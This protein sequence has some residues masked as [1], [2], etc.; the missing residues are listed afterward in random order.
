[1]YGWQKFRSDPFALASHVQAAFF[2]FGIF[3]P[4]AS[5]TEVFSRPYRAR[6]GR[7]ANAGVALVMKTIVGDVVLADIVPHLVMGPIDQRIDLH[8]VAVFPI[9]FDL[10]GLRARYR[11]LAP[12]AGHPGI[13]SAEGPLQ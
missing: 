12:Q 13:Q 4:P 1:M 6:A 3:P 11:L 7:A 8:E 2:G 10:P 9:Q 5:G